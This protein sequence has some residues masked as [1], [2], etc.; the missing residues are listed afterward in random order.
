[1]P[2]R[3]SILCEPRPKERRRVW[4]SGR[5]PGK[6]LRSIVG[7]GYLSA[8]QRLDGPRDHIAPLTSLRFFAALLIVLH[9]FAPVTIQGLSESTKRFLVGGAVGVTFFFVLSGFILTYTYADPQRAVDPRRFW[10]AR[11]ARIVPVYL[12]GLALATA[13]TLHHMRSDGWLDP[14]HRLVVPLVLGVLLLQAWFPRYCVSLNPPAWSLSAEAFFY[15]LIPLF[16]RPAITAPL[17]NRPFVFLVGFWILGI[18][19]C[20]IGLWG[21]PFIASEAWSPLSLV[22]TRS[23]FSFFP[24]LRLPE[25]LMGIVLGLL[26][27]QRSDSASLRSGNLVFLASVGAIAVLLATST[28][29]LR[30]LYHNALLAPLFCGVIWGAATST[31][32]LGS[33]LAHKGLRMLGEAS[34]S[35]YILHFPLKPVFSEL[36]RRTGMD[37]QGA[38][39]LGAYTLFSVAISIAAYAWI[40]K[41][42]REV[43]R[44]LFDRRGIRARKFVPPAQPSAETRRSSSRQHASVVGG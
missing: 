39:Y 28:P 26:Y 16:L 10:S 7:C 43:L 34:Y 38:A 23:F 15:G 32:W 36:L 11:I 12:A 8:M 30:V 27:L 6:G 2:Y 18:V 1:M 14:F 42:M 21:W 41:P 17:R 13:V 9:H 24:L 25:F 4:E 3:S 22:H 44:S 40:E 19:P 20:A 29:E 33:L 37:L 31:G 5:K 35:L